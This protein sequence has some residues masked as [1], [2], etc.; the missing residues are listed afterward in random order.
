[1]SDPQIIMSGIPQEHHSCIL[2]VRAYYQELDG[3]PITF[4]LQRGGTRAG[5]CDWKRGVIKLHP[6]VLGYR[7]PVAHELTHMVQRRVGGI[8]GGERAC[9]LYTLARSPNIVDLCPGYLDIPDCIRSG[10][11]PEIAAELS[12]MAR[13]AIRLRDEGWRRDYIRV[14]ERMCSGEQ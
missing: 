9:D 11:S 3:I 2:T 10:W 8:P 4:A 5:M 13:H 12:A 1:M 14:F 6:D 7:Y